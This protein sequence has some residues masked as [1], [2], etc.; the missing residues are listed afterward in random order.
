MTITMSLAANNNRTN[1]EENKWYFA[2]QND[3]F[4]KELINHPIFR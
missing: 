2:I 3:K 1:L 4:G